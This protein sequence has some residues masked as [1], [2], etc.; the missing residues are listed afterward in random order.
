MSEHPWGTARVTVQ[1]DGEGHAIVTLSY[2]VTNE[3]AI[4][5]LQ[6]VKSETTDEMASKMVAQLTEAGEKAPA[7]VL[8]LIRDDDDE[9]K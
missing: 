8:K 7:L 1:P 3:T 2:R 5:V 9:Q 4:E 6:F